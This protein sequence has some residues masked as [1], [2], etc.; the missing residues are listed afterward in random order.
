M[1]GVMD[2]EWSRCGIAWSLG[3]EN[4]VGRDIWLAK[5]QLGSEVFSR[6]VLVDLSL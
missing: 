4:A 2:V 3:V 6:R 1:D 5:V